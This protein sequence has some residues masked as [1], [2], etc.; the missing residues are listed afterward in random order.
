[1]ILAQITDTHIGEGGRAAFGRVDTAAALA[2]CIDAL[3][4]LDPAPDLVL[5]TGDLVERRTPEE[6]ARFREVLAGL[7]LPFRAIPG[8]HD[9][10]EPMRAAFADTDWMPREGDYLQFAIEHLPV[11]ILALDS[12]IPRRGSG[13]LDAA[14]LAWLEERLAEAPDR[15][16]IVALHH[17]P[18]P[19]GMPEMDRGGFGNADRFAALLARH[20]NVERV[21]CGHVHRAM[22][23]R[24]GGTIASTAPSMSYQ[25]ALDRRDGAP[26]SYAFEPPGF[27][28]HVWSEGVG[29]VTHL[30]PIGDYETIP[31]LKDGKVI[32]PPE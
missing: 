31:F 8:N 26:L 5:H 22:T 29:L 21:I 16:T 27:H 15:P 18:F 7:R 2:R 12:T 13:E 23:V 24:F 14:R 1:M 30:V 10:R 3:H 4:A 11:R 17:P 25:F 19:T 20:R 6:Y 32:R 28:L 9:A